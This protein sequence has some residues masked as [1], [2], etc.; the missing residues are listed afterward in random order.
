MSDI[1]RL[2][3]KA[4]VE[5][6]IKTDLEMQQFLDR[7]LRKGSYLRMRFDQERFKREKGKKDEK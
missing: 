4:K 2:L 6:K 7:W 5:A 1:Y 3:I